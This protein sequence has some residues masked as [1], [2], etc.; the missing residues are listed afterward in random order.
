MAD[1]HADVPANIPVLLGQRTPQFDG[2]GSA[3]DAEA[4]CGA[5]AGKVEKAG[6]CPPW[7]PLTAWF[8]MLYGTFGSFLPLAMLCYG[9]QQSFQRTTKG[10]AVKYY[11]MDEL[12]LDGVEIGRLV[13]AGHLVWNMRPVL[14]MLS[15][16]MPLC[17]Y[18]RTSY[19]VIM[20]CIAISMYTWIGFFPV[21]T[22]GLL[23]FIT[24][25]NGTVAFSDLL[26]DATAAGLAR[27]HPAEACDLQTAIRSAEAT[28]GIVSSAVKGALVSNFTPRGAIMSQSLCVVA[29]LIPAL[30]G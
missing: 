18:H 1:Q 15:D 12:K 14:A 20:C 4:T 23:A 30:R 11:M 10:F 5:H 7:R 6:R 17:G 28:G 29:V 27:S 26:V 19:L 25:V 9:L 2:K 13:T 21:S 24:V 3:E 22:L 16:A 8:Q